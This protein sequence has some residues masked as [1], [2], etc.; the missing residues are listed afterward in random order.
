MSKL[1][2]VLL[3]IALL[4][5]PACCLAQAEG[6]GG[7]PRHLGWVAQPRPGAA[8]TYSSD[9]DWLGLDLTIDLVP[10]PGTPPAPQFSRKN[11]NPF[12]ASQNVGKAALWS[13]VAFNVSGT[14][15][16][17]WLWQPPLIPYTQLP[18]LI[19][20][21]TPALFT[22]AYVSMNVNGYASDVSIHVTG[23][24]N[25]GGPEWV[26][27]DATP[28]SFDAFGPL[29]VGIPASMLARAVLPAGGVT[30]AVAQMSPTLTAHTIAA[31]TAGGRSTG[32]GSAQLNVNGWGIY[33]IVLR[34]PYPFGLPQ[35]GDGDNK[36]VYDASALGMLTVSMSAEV[37]GATQADTQWLVDNNKV[38]WTIHPGIDGWI[39]YT[40]QAQGS[41]IQPVTNGVGGVAMYQG[42]PDSDT[43]FGLKTLLLKVE[44]HDSQQAF[45][46][47]YFSASALNH[48]NFDLTPNWFYYYNKMFSA[49]PAVYENGTTSH[50]DSDSTTDP[51]PYHFPIV[52]GVFI[53]NDAYKTDIIPVFTPGATLVYDGQFFVNGI[54]NYLYTVGHELGHKWD[55]ENG[56]VNRKYKKSDAWNKGFDFDGD[57]VLNSAEIANGLDPQKPDTTGAFGGA[58]E[59]DVEAL[60]C[61]HGLAKLLPNKD[62][63]KRDWSSVGLQYN[64]LMGNEIWGNYNPDPAFSSYWGVPVSAPYF[65]WDYQK[66]VM[67]NGR[68]RPMGSHDADPPG[69]AVTQV[70][71]PFSQ[72]PYTDGK[73]PYPGQHIPLAASCGLPILRRYLEKKMRTLLVWLVALTVVLQGAGTLAQDSKPLRHKNGHVYRD[74]DDIGRVDA[75]HQAG[76]KHDRTQLPALLAAVS[77][78]PDHFHFFTAVHAL[79][80]IGDP[81]AL[82]ALD[83]AIQRLA[84]DKEPC[85]YAEVARARLLADGEAQKHTGQRQQAQTRLSTFLATLQLDANTLN[86]TVTRDWEHWMSNGGEASTRA[87]YAMR[88]LADMIYHT[89]DMAFAEAVKTAG[90]DFTTDAGAKY[91]VQLA[92]LTAQQRVDWIISEFSNKKVLKGDDFYLMQLAADE[93][94]LASRA[95][96]ATLKEMDK[97]RERYPSL[98]TKEAGHVNHIGFSALFDVIRAVGDKDQE[99][100]IAHFL[101]DKEKWIAYYANQVYPSITT[102]IPWKWRVGY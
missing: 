29:P 61:I 83:A 78:P 63:W 5:F 44:S 73:I 62:A 31:P 9:F 85:E 32:D 28:N 40:K 26:D 51:Q 97:H 76:L 17:K 47:T 22:M 41:Y 99:P 59:G 23:I 92:P 11:Y 65:P 89:R 21:P 48:P 90:V 50:C 80:R 67:V 12:G 91:K 55:I 34:S 54:H 81:Q 43:G 87:Q 72:P 37:V 79:V 46:Q 30:M 101:N 16:F 33:P 70:I 52:K 96:A 13:A 19:R 14:P 66:L 74:F 64:G 36:F 98:L 20:F 25:P 86:V 71:N 39:P 84:D 3:L 68:P 42:L 7:G 24:V 53:D 56:L 18:D 6:G 82:P 95:A 2:S 27:S 45:I 8:G 35:M 58:P 38:G 69:N 60:A 10:W 93:G 77:T 49:F 100:V 88:E 15:T 1:Y 75:L 102:G 94:K 4:L 57:G